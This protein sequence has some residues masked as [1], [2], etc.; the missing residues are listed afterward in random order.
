M[1]SPPGDPA[2]VPRWARLSPARIRIAVRLFDVALIVGV[3]MA[4]PEG[5]GLLRP[6]AL[7]MG[8]L[9]WAA[10]TLMIIVLGGASLLLMSLKKVPA[11]DRRSNQVR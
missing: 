2:P 9:L 7:A 5:G 10:Q 1:P 8:W 4:P 11:H 6:D 3:Y